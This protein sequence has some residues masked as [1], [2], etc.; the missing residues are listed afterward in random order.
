MLSDRLHGKNIFSHNERRKP[1]TRPSQHSSLCED[2]KSHKRAPI[3]CATNLQKGTQE[4]P[5]TIQAPFKETRRQAP[6][7]RTGCAQGRVVCSKKAGYKK[8]GSR[9]GKG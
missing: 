7:Q 2:E 9:W 1:K 8:H 5:K 6:E 4:R 3:S